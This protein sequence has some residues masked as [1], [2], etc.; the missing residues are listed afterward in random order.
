MLFSL[1]VNFFLILSDF[2]LKTR[3]TYSLQSIF[4]IELQI[5]VITV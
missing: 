2:S 5:Y 3:F 4:V 1:F